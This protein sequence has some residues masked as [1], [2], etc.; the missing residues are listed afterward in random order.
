MYLGQVPKRTSDVIR[1]QTIDFTFLYRDRSEF[2][3][4]NKRDNGDIVRE[5]KNGNLQEKEEEK[6]EEEK[7]IRVRGWR[8][9]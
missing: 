1:Y 6:E 3:K 7:G 4:R 9:A 2:S 5:L 8:I